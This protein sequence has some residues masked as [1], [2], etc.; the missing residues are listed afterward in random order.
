M[1]L[2]SGCE[3]HVWP[4]GAGLVLRRGWPLVAA[5]PGM[6]IEM[7]EGE[8]GVPS[9]DLLAA[10][11]L[12]FNVRRGAPPGFTPV[13]VGRSMPGFAGSVLGNPFRVGHSRARGEAVA[14]YLPWLRAKFTQ[15]G[16]ER[17][18]L[19]DLAR[20]VNAEER[21]LLGCWCSPLACHADHVRTAVL[22]CAIWLRS[23]ER[24]G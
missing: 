5:W 4:W 14:A 23:Q 19:I 3:E 16:A 8:S 12:V 21:T 18:A 22:G 6:P 7:I 2:A 24:D 10:R 20:R 1:A 11:V 9:D 15:D 13:Y 17:E